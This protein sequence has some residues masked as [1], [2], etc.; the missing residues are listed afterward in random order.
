MIITKSIE[1]KRFLR[2]AAVG[3]IGAVIDFGVFNILTTILGMLGVYAQTI[4]FTTAVVS[5]FVWNR[6]WTYP[7]SRSKPITKQVLQFLVVSIT[8]LG[9]RTLLFAWLEPIL[10]SLSSNLI[11]FSNF[12]LSP[13]QLGYNITLAIGVGVV[14]LWNF[15]I[16]RFWTYSDVDEINKKE[17]HSELW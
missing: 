9:I 14:M 6:Y 2:F 17:T 13:I 15:Y 7:D 12:P 11:D 5:N 3:V 8:G 10:I 16:N 4:S 1:R